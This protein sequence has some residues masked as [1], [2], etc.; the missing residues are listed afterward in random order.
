M[1]QRLS[2][3][4]FAAFLSVFAA[5]PALSAA[6]GVVSLPEVV[7]TGSRIAGSIDEIASPVYV[8]T[9][10][11]IAATGARTVADILVSRVPGINQSNR[12]GWAQ[13]AEV[14]V[15]GLTTQMLVLVDGIPFYRSSHIAG[16][17][18]IDLHSISAESVERIEVVKGASSAMYG[19]LAAAGVINVITQKGDSR[20]GRVTIEAGPDGL[21]RY[22]ATAAASNDLFRLNAY[23]E[24]TEEGRR[25]IY[26]TTDEGGKLYYSDSYE[27]DA[28]GITI[29]R[30]AWSFRAEAG[31]Y[32]NIFEDASSPTYTPPYTAVVNKEEKTYSR[33]ALSYSGERIHALLGYDTQKREY[34][35]IAGCSYDDRSLTTDIYAPFMIGRARAV[36]GLFYRKEWTTFRE[37]LAENEKDHSRSNVAPYLEVSL[38]AGDILVNAGVRYEYWDQEDA[39]NHRELMPK[40]SVE[41]QTPGGQTWYLSAGRFFAM[42]S[43]YE[44]YT[45]NTMWLVKGNP[46]LKPEKGWSYDAGVRGKDGLGSW[47]IGVFAMFMDDKIVFVSDPVTYEGTYANIAEFRSFGIETERSWTLDGPFSARLSGTWMRAEERSSSGAE[48]RRSLRTPEWTMQGSLRYD[49]NPWSAELAVRYIDDRPYSTT[50]DDGSSFLTDLYVEWTSPRNKAGNN[51]RVRLSC[52]NL[53]DEPYEF[54]SL[55]RVYLSPERSFVLSVSMAF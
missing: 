14:T 46:N 31:S 33:Y 49:R 30:G 23:A 54:T 18:A 42:P 43:F 50:G 52:L 8:I 44:L 26:R 21:R 10:A 20:G 19:S 55:N 39:E 2:F 27:G 24:R 13:D 9:S 7:V 40:L 6:P 48:W 4:T 22:A 17:A 16:G 34:P 53:F 1:N 11:D 29:S 45:T 12:M 28:G 35:H 37:E 32:T 51:Y 25:R 5:C 41:Y 36:G 15:R 38:P 47:Q 3:F